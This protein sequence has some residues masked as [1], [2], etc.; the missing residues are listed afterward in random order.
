M[1]CIAKAMLAC[2]SRVVQHVVHCLNSLYNTSVS[3]A[4]LYPLNVKMYVQHV[5]SYTSI[6]AQTFFADND[7]QYFNDGFKYSR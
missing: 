1:I 4:N 3:F 7:Q 2:K 5:D 6:V